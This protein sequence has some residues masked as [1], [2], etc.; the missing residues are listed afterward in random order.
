MKTNIH[1]YHIA[2]ISSQ[3]KKCFRNTVTT[4]FTLYNI[5]FK[6]VPFLRYVV[7][8]C[9]AEEVTDENIAHAHCIL[10]TY[11]YKYTIRICNT[12]C[13]SCNNGCTNAPQ[14][15]IICSLHCL[16]CLNITYFPVRQKS[17]CLYHEEGIRTAKL[18]TSTARP[19]YLL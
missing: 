18:Y 14:C 6:F 19:V 15:Y 3:K 7:K 8:H 5:F 13:C 2:L 12:Y 11:G 9:T 10:D 4:F 17:A 1:F 16:S